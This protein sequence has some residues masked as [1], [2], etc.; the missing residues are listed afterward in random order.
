MGTLGRTCKALRN[1]KQ[2]K[3]F[4][5]I[6]IFFCINTTELDVTLKKLV[7]QKFA[8]GRIKWSKSS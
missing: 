3:L 2:R 8:L 7:S 1:S 6:A 5:S 4:P